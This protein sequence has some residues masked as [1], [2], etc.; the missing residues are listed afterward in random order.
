MP[1]GRAYPGGAVAGPHPPPPATAAPTLDAASLRALRSVLA[2]LTGAARSALGAD[3]V[4]VYLVGSFA[5]GH[6]DAHSDVDF[7]VVT[8]REVDP[9]QERALRA[10]HAALPDSPVEWAR[11]LEGSYVSR[12][13]LRRPRDPGPGS[14]PGWL[15]VDNG[16]RVLERS[17][18]D[19]TAVARWVLRGHGIVLAGPDPVTL[20]DPVTP[21]Q[22]RCE[23]R[24]TVERWGAA[25]AADPDDIATAWGQQ[26]EVL[27]LCRFL[28][29]VVTGSVGAK[30]PSGRWALRSLDRRWQGLVQRAIDDRPDPWAR[31]HRPADP[32][33]LDPTRAFAAYAVAHARA[34]GPGGRIGSAGR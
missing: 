8:G 14:G 30:V 24:D 32:A 26:H 13:A 10:V 20:V 4:G 28:Y 6:G 22:I 29:S 31:V 25:L 18:H 12:A 19:D 27:G 33:L 11:H 16:S 9:G 21:E 17:A 7:L 34:H 5:L 1:G 2:E 23:A 3:L 15:Y